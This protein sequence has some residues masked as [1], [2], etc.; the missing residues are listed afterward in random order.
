MARKFCVRCGVEEGPGT[1]IIDGLCPKCFVKERPLLKLPSKLSVTVC[2]SCGAVYVGGQWDNPGSSLEEAVEYYMN[3]TL[4]KRTTVY[5]GLEDVRVEVESISSG[6]VYYRVTGKYGGVTLAQ[7]G[8]AY[9]KV[10]RKLC[11]VCSTV[12]YGK[13]EA[14]IQIRT[15]G[16]PRLEVFREVG[17]R[18]SRIKEFEQSV[19]EIKE[20]KNGVDLKMKDQSS[21]RYIATILR[22]E[23]AA[24]IKQ[25]WKDYGYVSGKKYGKL[26]ISVRLPGV[27]A[28]DIIEYEGAPAVVLG[29]KQGRVI[30]KRLSDGKVMGLS[31]DDL[32]VKGFKFLT[33]KDYA[34]IQ[35][36]V[37]NYEGGKAVVQAEESGNILY[38]QAPKIFDLG[39][40]VKILIYKGKTYLL[41]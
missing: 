40:P 2:S 1:P 16:P 32:W 8:V 17:R 25:T 13:Y 11:P 6:K 20:D 29:I 28:G 34:I 33:S 10:V 21:A 22:K 38:I 18:V 27:L 9:L 7:N 26:T 4:V 5:P 39:E 3:R 19:V 37:L 12:K 31:H 30:I 14:T 41:I 35:G 15:E 23:F 24:K 36:R